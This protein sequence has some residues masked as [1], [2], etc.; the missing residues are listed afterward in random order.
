MLNSLAMVA[1]MAAVDVCWVRTCCVEGGAD[2]TWCARMH[3]RESA[4]TIISVEVL[5][6]D[7]LL[8]MLV[9]VVCVFNAVAVFRFVVLLLVL[10]FKKAVRFNH[11]IL[12]SSSR[13]CINPNYRGHNDQV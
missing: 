10:I 4:Y 1:H 8:L 7:L 9:L 12:K 3:T 6:A 13:W 2:D 5:G 11:A